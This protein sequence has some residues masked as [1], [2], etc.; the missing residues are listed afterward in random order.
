MKNK[1]NQYGIEITKPWSQQMYDHN[2]KVALIVKENLFNA[3]TKAYKA[4]DE[5]SLRDIAKA[6]CGYGFGVGYEL[7]DIYNDS[8][9][10]L[11]RVQNFWLNSEYPH[12]VQMGYCVPLE[13]GF[14]GY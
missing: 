4:D 14:I 13:I 3:L 2:D 1:K 10:E 9:A 5:E 8:C 6:I 12:L 7:D 11:D